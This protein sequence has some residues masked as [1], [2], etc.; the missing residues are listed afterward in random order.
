MGHLIGIQQRCRLPC[1]STQSDPCHHYLLSGTHIYL[2][3]HAA[4]K[5]SSL[6]RRVEGYYFYNPKDSI[7]RVEAQIIV[8]PVPV[9]CSTS[10]RD[11]FLFL[12]KTFVLYYVFTSSE[13]FGDIVFVFFFLR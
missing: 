13:D 11:R 7:S 9:A 8:R 1:P 3:K 12:L 2:Y 10:Y 4:S 6:E 5:I